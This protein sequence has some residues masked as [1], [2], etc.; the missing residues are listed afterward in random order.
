MPTAN[1]HA[2]FRTA[3]GSTNECIAALD[4]ADALGYFAASD[5]MRDKLQYVRAT[6][7][8]LVTNRR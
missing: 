7:L 6:L 1:R 4:A 5:A 3:L 8:R 2:R